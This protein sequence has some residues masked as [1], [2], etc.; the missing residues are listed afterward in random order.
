MCKIVQGDYLIFL[1]CK[2]GY[3]IFIFP[4][5]IDTSSITI[6]IQIETIR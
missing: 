5:K 1:K 2:I 6:A 4:K 3:L